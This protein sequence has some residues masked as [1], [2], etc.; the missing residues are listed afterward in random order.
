MKTRNLENYK[1]HCTDKSYGIIENC[2]FNNVVNF[3]V[4]RNLS[5]D[6]MHDLL[7][8]ICRY[9]IAKILHHFICKKKIF[10]IGVL[11]DRIK[12]FGHSSFDKNIPVV[13]LESIIKG[14][15]ILSASEMLYLISHL[16]LFIGDLIPIQNSVWKLYLMLRKIVNISTL[17]SINNDIVESFDVLIS[18]YLELYLKVFKCSLK[19]KHHYLTH[20]GRIMREFGPLKNFSTMRFEGKHKQLKDYSKVITSRKCP[21][22]SLSLKHQMQLCHRF[23]CN[24]GFS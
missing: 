15:I 6:P 11:N 19:V 22:Y 14:V 8:G 4:T 20:Y 21:V 18:K 13:T 7:E 17:D 10:S 3:H 2:I 9:D 23:V 12:N 5:I 16:G 1:K 24:E